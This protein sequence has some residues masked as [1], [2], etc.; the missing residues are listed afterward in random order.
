[1]VNGAVAIARPIAA[2]HWYGRVRAANY[3]IVV[4]QRYG[5]AGAPLPAHFHPYPWLGQQVAHVV[6]LLAVHGEQPER[7]TVQ[8][9]ADGRVTEPSGTTAG[10]LQ[11]R[12]GR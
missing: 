1:M 4:G 3:R 11:Q 2:S 5:G 8:A 12:E 6:G 10:G 9:V 7:V